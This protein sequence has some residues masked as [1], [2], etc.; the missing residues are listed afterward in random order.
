MTTTRLR[1]RYAGCAAALVLLGVSPARS[2][3]TP[4][5]ASGGVAD[6]VASVDVDGCLARQISRVALMDLR[7]A[8]SPQAGDYGVAAIVLGIA[9][10]YA[11]DNVELARRRAEAAWNWGDPEELDAATRR[12]IEL[13]HLDTM[14]QLRLL[15]SRLGSIQ[16]VEE[17]IVAFDRVGDTG[18]LDASIRGRFLLDASLLARE[19]GDEIGFVRRLSRAIEL[20]S[21]NKEAAVLALTFFE[22]R[23]NDRWGRLDLVTNLLLADPLDPQVHA[24]LV[25]ELAAGGAYDG[26]RRFIRN[27]A[28]LAKQNDLPLSADNALQSEVLDVLCDGATQTYA[29]Y[30]AELSRARESL[31]GRL[32]IL[33][34]AGQPTVGLPKPQDIRLD[35]DRESIRILCAL[36]LGDQPGAETAISELGLTAHDNVKKL[37]DPLQRPRDISEADAIEYARVAVARAELWR[38]ATGVDLDKVE[39]DLPAA[40]EHAKA[41]SVDV[42]AI[43]AMVAA[44][45]GETAK[46]PEMLK[47]AED[48]DPWLRVASGLALELSGDIQGAIA[49]YRVGQ[50]EAPLAPQGV[51]AGILADR[52]RIAHSLPVPPERAAIRRRLEEKAGEISLWIDEMARD[53]RSFEYLEARLDQ[54]EADALAPA[55]ATITIRNSSPKPLALGAGKPINSRL[56]IAQSVDAGGRSL[57]NLASAEVVD[58]QRRLRL[59]PGETEAIRYALDDGPTGWLL[60]TLSGSSGQVRLRVVQ[61]FEIKPNGARDPGPGCIETMSASLQRRPLAEVRLKPSEL[62]ALIDKA[63][64]ASLPKL[65]A[66]ARSQIVLPQP[67]GARVVIDAVVRRYP[68][69]SPRLRCLVL[70][71]MPNAAEL[72]EL[73]ALD[74]LVEEERDPQVL[75]IAIVTRAVDVKSPLLARAASSGD[76]LLARLAELH[77]ARLAAGSK[78]YA[79]QGTGLVQPLRTMYGVKG[80]EPVPA[81][82]SSAAAAP[83]HQSKSSEPLAPPSATPP[84]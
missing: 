84:R 49:E 14:A 25:R 64:E 67:D 4:A 38:L 74:N 31:A 24:R 45:A 35:M 53:P 81:A 17:K 23:S 72:P 26:A 27:I 63:A 1:M 22:Q 68:A 66:A 48:E 59:L 76:A 36:M 7:A 57:T 52:V 37:L 82:G 79:L 15:S 83:H 51:L 40:Y 2:Q 54:P 33:E 69:L 32:K 9:G 19:Q 42:C 58:G 56:L 71:V 65:L 16:T 70:A 44:R 60:E 62:A 78:C 80:P 21:T 41:S 20:D 46:A 5:V 30:N 34:D 39:A 50:E 3:T 12:I 13:D 55:Y 43:R 28:E 47:A 77:T 61:G 8:A 10:R 6:S 75:G 18:E 73:T 29:D 11:P